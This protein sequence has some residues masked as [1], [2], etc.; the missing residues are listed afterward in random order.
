MNLK[1]PKTRVE[2]DKDFLSSIPVIVALIMLG[3]APLFLLQDELAI[4]NQFAGYAYYF[5]II[6][7]LWKIIQYL[8]NRSRHEDELE[9][10]DR[11]T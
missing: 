5:L 8:T 3:S 4:A 2:I 7:V 10:L 1:L 6:S 11:Q 9:R